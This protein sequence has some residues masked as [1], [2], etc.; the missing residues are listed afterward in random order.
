MKKIILL[1]ILFSLAACTNPSSDECRS[2]AYVTYVTDSIQERAVK[3]FI[4]SVRELGGDYSNCRVYLIVEDIEKSSFSSFPDKNIILLKLDM[5]TIFRDYPLAIKAFAAAQAEELARDSISTLAWF[6]PSTLLLNTPGELDLSGVYSV[7]IRPVTLLNNI[8]IKAGSPPDDYWNPI[9]SYLDLA[10]DSIPVV[11]TI[12]GQTDILAYFNCEI[13]SFDPKAGIC[14]EWRTMLTKF[15]Q[16]EDFQRTVCNTPLRRLFLHQAILSGVIVSR[17]PHDKIKELSIKNGYPFNQHDLLDEM[18]RVNSLNE[19][20]ALILDYA[21]E[22]DP[23]WAE[24]IPVLP[25]LKG[26][27]METY[28]D[29]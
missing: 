4:K 16:D 3:A 27:L 21:W 9:Y 13:F 7:A 17:I 11:K 1:L 10:T 12:V 28:A 18:H 29:Y 24:K 8:G 5:D 15:L 26:W 14:T 6:D 22:T 2:F 19:L 23:G 20:N 25:P